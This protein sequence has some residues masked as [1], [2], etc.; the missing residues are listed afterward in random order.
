MQQK[1]DSIRKVG[2]VFGCEESGLTNAALQLCDLAVT[3]PTKTTYPSLN[4]AQ[5]VMLMAYVF[6]D[7]QKESLS[8][9]IPNSDFELLKTKAA[10]FLS[11]AG[12]NKD[13]NLFG[14][15]M[16]RLARTNQTDTRLL[17]SFMN[18][19]EKKIK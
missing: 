4:L 17:L 5:A 1:G 8:E 2:L 14:R 13:E 11:L 6:S 7:F 15:I 3:I 10:G 19:L 9:T 16:E 12:I 18:K